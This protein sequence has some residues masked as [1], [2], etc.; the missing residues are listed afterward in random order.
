MW[1]EYGRKGGDEEKGSR[2]A[3][4][5]DLT[6]SV[7][8]GWER[9]IWWKDTNF[10]GVWWLRIE[11]A[12]VGSSEDDWCLHSSINVQISNASHEV[13]FLVTNAKEASPPGEASTKWSVCKL[14]RQPSFELK[15]ILKAKFKKKKG[16]NRQIKTFA[17]PQAYVYL[18][19]KKNCTYEDGSLLINL[20]HLS[21]LSLLSVVSVTF[22]LTCQK[23]KF[24]NTG[25]ACEAAT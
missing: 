3:G 1:Q 23:N 13:M 4:T 7:R 24:E 16:Y 10:T 18:I 14:K 11:G 15:I 5:N 6:K 19:E 12:I 2:K 9:Q 8:G 21:M 22:V 17:L 25:W 20:S